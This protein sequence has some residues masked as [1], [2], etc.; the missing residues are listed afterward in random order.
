M[1]R[2]CLEMYTSFAFSNIFKIKWP[3]SESKFNFRDRCVWVPMNRTPIKTSWRRTWFWPFRPAGVRKPQGGHTLSAPPPPWLRPCWWH[4]RWPGVTI[5]TKGAEKLYEQLYQKM[6]ALRYTNRLPHHLNMVYDHA[7]TQSGRDTP[8]A[9]SRTP[10]ARRLA[11]ASRPQYHV[12]CGALSWPCRGC[13][14]AGSAR[15]GQC[16]CLPSSVWGAPALGSDRGRE[17][18]RFGWY[19]SECEWNFVDWRVLFGGQQCVEEQNSG[20]N[21]GGYPLDGVG[22]TLRGIF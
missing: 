4:L 5:F 11:E 20:Q 21:P 16:C 14:P 8:P 7:I 19:R 22:S 6:A 1:K 9:R 3:K 18:A 17:G 12:T 13:W 15:A 2:L 10:S